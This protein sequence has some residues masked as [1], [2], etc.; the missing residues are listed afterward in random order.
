MSVSPTYFNKE[1]NNIRRVFGNSY[2]FV[3]D[4]Y[5]NANVSGD[6]GLFSSIGRN[7]LISNLGIKFGLINISTTADANIG[8]LAGSSS[9]TIF[10]V[11]V[12]A[13]PSVDTDY[14]GNTQ[15]KTVADFGNG[16][17]N[18]YLSAILDSQEIATLKVA[19]LQGN[20]VIGGLVGTASG[21]INN[22]FGSIDMSIRGVGDQSIIGGLVGASQWASIS[23]V[24]TNGRLNISLNSTIGGMVG[25]AQESY[26]RGAIANV[27]MGVFVPDYDATLVGYAFGDFVDGEYVGIIA[28][29]DISATDS[30][31]FDNELYSLGQT[32]AKLSSQEALDFILDENNLFDTTLW[33]QDVT[34][35]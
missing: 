30:E 27:N 22:T 23:N 24:M 33:V 18:K 10:N 32:T 3:L 7:Q 35:N 12:G 13:L 6:F 1:L 17:S 34:K 31:Y 19:V 11:S 20:S 5:S 21:Y 26:I 15:Q 2:S 28:N 25:M 9:G 16:V 8:V 14:M 4:D 29:T